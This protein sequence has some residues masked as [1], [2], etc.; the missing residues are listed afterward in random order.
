M[1]DAQRIAYLKRIIAES[2][3]TTKARNAQWLIDEIKSTP[4][5]IGLENVVAGLVFK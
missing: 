5:L 3:N 4:K 2:P 1:T